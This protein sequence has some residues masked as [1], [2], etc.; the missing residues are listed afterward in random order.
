MDPTASEHGNPVVIASGGGNKAGERLP[1]LTLRRG[2]CGVFIDFDRLPELLSIAATRGDSR[3]LVTAAWA[4]HLEARGFADEHVH[5]DDAA[6]AAIAVAAARDA[7]RF[8]HR[9]GLV[10]EGGVTVEGNRLIALAQ[11]A[12]SPAAG[13]RGPTAEY[14]ARCLPHQLRGQGD[15]DLLPLLRA[16]AHGL[17]TTTHPWASLCPGLLPVEVGALIHWGSID[18]D[19]ARRLLADLVTWRDVA[20]HSY[21]H[22]HKDDVPPADNANRHFEVV[23]AFYQSHAWLAERAP[24][25]FGEEFATCKLLDYCG[26]FRLVMGRT[27]PA[28]WL[29]EALPGGDPS[30][31]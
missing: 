5:A 31:C 2:L 23:S 30:A 10:D 25:T 15:G 4:T 11:R 3:Q 16:G 9:V 6:G 21:E 12:Q 19:R 27:P 22:P 26:V 13:G 17:A 7:W 24:L 29:V 14:L 1:S 20:M 28:C 8:S 18:L